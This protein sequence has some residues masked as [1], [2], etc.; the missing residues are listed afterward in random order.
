[1]PN[2]VIKEVN[3]T[4]VTLQNANDVFTEVFQWEVGKDIEVKLMRDGNEV[5]IKTKTTQ[6]Y[7]TGKSL[8]VLDTAT[9]AENDLRK[10][11]LK[12]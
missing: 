1:M 10:A 7:T 4:A 6:S 11:W 3:G 5:V 12:G 8:K 2:D 9:G